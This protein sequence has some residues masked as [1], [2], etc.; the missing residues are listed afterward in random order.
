MAEQAQVNFMWK[1]AATG[2]GSFLLGLSVMFANTAIQDTVDHGQ[3]AREKAGLY[4]RLDSIDKELSEVKES[5]K[6]LRAT[7]SELNKAI[8]DLRIEIARWADASKNE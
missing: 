1:Y 3:Y 8:V 5:D 6:E 2:L 4:A 7:L